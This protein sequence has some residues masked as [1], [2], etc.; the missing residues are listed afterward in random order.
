M[1]P[2]DHNILARELIQQL[3]PCRCSRSRI[4]VEDHRDLG[5]RQLDALGMDGVTQKKI[6]CPFDE[7]SKPACPGV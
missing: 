1:R 6:F 2:R 7:N 5:M 3:T 4:D